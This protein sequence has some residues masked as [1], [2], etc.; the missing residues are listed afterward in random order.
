MEAV[1]L[2]RFNSPTDMSFAANSVALTQAETA[3]SLFLRLRVCRKDAPA[4][5]HTVCQLSGEATPRNLKRLAASESAESPRSSQPRLA[6]S[7]IGNRC[8]HSDQ[9]A[10]RSSS[11]TRACA[12]SYL[13]WRLSQKC[14]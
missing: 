13:R 6:I 7:L 11:R 2:A 1:S 9:L 5:C 8:T 12:S 14:A 10:E 4:A 3:S